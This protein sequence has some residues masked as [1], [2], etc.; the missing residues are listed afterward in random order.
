M[1]QPSLGRTVIIKSG[2]GNEYPAIV[3]AVHGANGDSQNGEYWCVSACAFPPGRTPETH[4]SIYL[5]ADR[6]AAVK[7]Q[8]TADLKPH[9]AFWP[10]R[11]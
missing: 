3:N 10:E 2:S 11:V 4:T 1:Q 9:I 6:D 5:F 8:G 7:Y